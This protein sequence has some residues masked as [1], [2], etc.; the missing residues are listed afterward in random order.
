MP[1]PV[2]LLLAAGASRRFGDDKLLYPLAD[3]LP[4]ALQAY[5][6]L[7]AAVSSV[8]AVV[9]A[10]GSLSGLL[11]ARGCEVLVFAEAERGMGASIAFGVENTRNGVG[12][13]IALADMP[14]IRPETHAAVTRAL[15]QDAPLVAPFYRGQRGHP[16]GFGAQFAED[17]CVLQGD[18]GAKSILMQHRQLLRR[19]ECEDAGILI[20]IDT[21]E[22]LC[23]ETCS[24]AST[25]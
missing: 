1:E 16:V 2:A 11:R 4:V 13:I 22:D 5:E 23:A 10:E 12:W 7:K 15:M 14:F 6:N 3:R 17:L 8:V 20:D 24:T 9:K 25:N 18:R 19:I 21:A